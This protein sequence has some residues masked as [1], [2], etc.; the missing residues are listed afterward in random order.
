MS[1]GRT[2]EKEGKIIKFGRVTSL[3]YE[4]DTAD[5]NYLQELRFGSRLNGIP[6]SQQLFLFQM[7]TRIHIF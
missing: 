1:Q 6:V 5:V 4:I 3:S 7:E 2:K